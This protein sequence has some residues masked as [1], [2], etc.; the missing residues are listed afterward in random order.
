[1]V[2]AV[3]LAIYGFVDLVLLFAAVLVERAKAPLHALGISKNWK[4]ANRKEETIERMCQLEKSET[5]VTKI[6]TKGRVTIPAELRK[7]FGIKKGTP[8]DWE[9]DGRRLVLTPVKRLRKKS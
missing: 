7:R 9:R 6:S 4:H 5:R 2:M 8:I 3:V 1:M